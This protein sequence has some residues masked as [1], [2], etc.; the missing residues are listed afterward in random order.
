MFE[1]TFRT[2]PGYVCKGDDKCRSAVVYMGGVGF[3]VKWCWGILEVERSGRHSRCIDCDVIVHGLEL[4]QGGEH[5][6]DCR[7]SFF[8]GP[9]QTSMW[10]TKICLLFSRAYTYS[11][12]SLQAYI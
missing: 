6:K 2:K 7:R 10:L 11:F 5:R 9:G 4:L 3:L 12:F 8:C 1:G